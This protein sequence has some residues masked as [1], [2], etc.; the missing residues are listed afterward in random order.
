MKSLQGF[1]Q[2]LLLSLILDYKPRSNFSKQFQDSLSFDWKF[3]FR[4]LILM[5][6]ILCTVIKCFLNEKFNGSGM[7][8]VSAESLAYTKIVVSVAQYIPRSRPEMGFRRRFFSSLNLFGLVG[9]C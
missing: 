5:K 8:S 9:S 3:Y 4:G 1:N 7:V 2:F 6:K